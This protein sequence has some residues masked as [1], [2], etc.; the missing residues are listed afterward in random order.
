M[1]IE[2]LHQKVVT[3]MHDGGLKAKFIANFKAAKPALSANALEQEWR[4]ALTVIHR[5]KV[6]FQNISFNSL[7]TAKLARGLECASEYGLSFLPERKEMYLMCSFDIDS[8]PMFEAKLGY[9]GMQ[10]LLMRTGQVAR[11]AY[12]VVYEGDTFAWYGMDNRPTHARTNGSS[13]RSVQCGYSSFELTDKSVISTFV[14]KEELEEAINIRN[15]ISMQNTGT[16]EESL[17]VGPYRH[18]ILSILV[19]KKTYSTIKHQ[20]ELR[21]V[22]VSKEHDGFVLSDDDEF[23]RNLQNEMNAEVKHA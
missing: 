2:S 9:N 14:S 3:L 21:G 19:I 12:D 22:C 18:K 15:R 5:D 8:T 11:F 6:D 1:E 16:L 23:I 10:I 20:L 17:V 13:F 4:N 7:S